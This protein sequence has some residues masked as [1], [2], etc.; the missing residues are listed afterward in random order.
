MSEIKPD[1]QMNVDEE[2]KALLEEWRA[3]N[4]PESL[5]KRVTAAYRRQISGAV[6]ASNPMFSHRDSE[7]VQMKQCSTCHEEFADKFSFCPVD[8]TPLA[9]QAAKSI[10]PEPTV[11]QPTIPAL[12]SQEESAPAES[13][14]LVPVDDSYHLTI[15][16]DAGLLSRLMAELREVSHESQLTW[17]EFKRDPAG[18]I[19]RSISS[20]AALLGRFVSQPGVGAAMAVAVGSMLLLMLGVILLERTRSAGATRAVVIGFG[21]IA[22]GMLVTIFASWFSRDT[23]ATVGVSRAGALAGARNDSQ[24]ALAGMIAAFVFI[25]FV[26]GGVIGWNLYSNW[27]HNQ[28]VAADRVREDLEYQ[29]DISIPQE[30]ETPKPGAAGMNK[31]NGGGSKPKQDR[32]GGGG[33]GGREEQTPA[34]HGVTP[35]ASLTIPQVLAPDP[36]PNNIPHPSL[37]TAA[38]IEADPLL[39]PTTV[40][41]YGDPHSTATTPSSGPGTGNGIGTGTG[42]GIGPGNGTGFGP[43]NERNTGGGDFHQGGGGPGGGGGGGDDPNKIYSTREV[44]VKARIIAKPEAPY[45]EE[46]RRNQITGTVTLRAVLA[47]NGTITGIRS[48]SG[49]PYGLTEQ[50]IEAAHRIKFVPAQRDGRAVSQYIQIEYNFNLY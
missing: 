39:F 26:V 13:Y 33:G 21:L 32:P 5:D 38:T 30:Q 46:A 48:V 8:G 50:A 40:G 28:Q 36:H 18:F 24:N 47:S 4:P 7:V 1:A 31:G 17:P 14:A 19:K 29:G 27:R 11:T 23:E 42:S 22:V 43:G 44:T 3:P 35:Q 45:T 6:R 10:K 15:L 20:Y 12:A 25:F 9:S 16:D 49:L 34:S 41:A 37:P 2:L